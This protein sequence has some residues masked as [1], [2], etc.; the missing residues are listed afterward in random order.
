MTGIQNYLETREKRIKELIA[1]PTTIGKYFRDVKKE[2]TLLNKLTATEKSKPVFTKHK[3]P[4]KR[5]TMKIYCRRCMKT[6]Q[7]SSGNVDVWY[8]GSKGCP[9]SK[10]NEADMDRLLDDSTPHND[11]PFFQ[12]M[13]KQLDAKID[14]YTGYDGEE[15]DDDID[16]EDDDIQDH[17]DEETKKKQPEEQLNQLL[18]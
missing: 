4:N 1:K 13:A 8:C 2:F 12:R 16:E 6:F 17:P 3:D 7:R 10:L 14:V 9:N 11:I 18:Q 15:D 5:V